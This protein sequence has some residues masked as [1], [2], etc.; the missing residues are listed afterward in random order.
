MHSLYFVFI[1]KIHRHINKNIINFKQTHQL[2]K[3]NFK[4]GKRMVVTASSKSVHIPSN[5]IYLFRMPILLFHLLYKC[6]IA[7]LIKAENASPAIKKSDGYII[8]LTFQMAKG[9]SSNSNLK[10][11]RINNF[12]FFYRM[13]F[14]SL[15]TTT[16]YDKTLVT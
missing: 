12:L 3:L 6:E 7:L 15:V 14:Y 5:G 11:I 1:N 13:K 16:C 8:L 2:S 4:N 9:H 10:L